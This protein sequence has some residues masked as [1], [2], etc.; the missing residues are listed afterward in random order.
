MPSVKVSYS[1]ERDTGTGHLCQML[2]VEH[3]IAPQGKWEEWYALPEVA[4]TYWPHN[5]CNPTFFRAASY[6][7]ERDGELLMSLKNFMGWN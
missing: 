2:E 5:R 4:D 7:P 1:T 3:P 6:G